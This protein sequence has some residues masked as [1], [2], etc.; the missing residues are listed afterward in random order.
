MDKGGKKGGGREYP[1]PTQGCSNLQ[2]TVKTLA[3]F[4]T[5]TP[6]NITVN[7]PDVLSPCTVIINVQI[8]EYVTL[9]TSL[10]E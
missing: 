9:I 5:Y 8:I 1:G 10:Y 3:T 2:Y 4:Q 6:V 7:Q